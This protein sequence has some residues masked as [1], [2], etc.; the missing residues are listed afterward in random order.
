MADEKKLLNNVQEDLTGYWNGRAKAYSEEIVEE[1]EDDRREIWRNLIL[2]QSPGE[3]C[4]ES[5]M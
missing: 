2:S 3:K 5:W 4:C 1:M